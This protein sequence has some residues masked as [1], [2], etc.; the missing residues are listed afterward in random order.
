MHALT[1][2]PDCRASFHELAEAA[3]SWLRRQL[4]DVPPER[5]VYLLGEGW[6]GVLALQLAWDCRCGEQGL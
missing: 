3:G 5:P 4:A 2:E 1:L 6:G